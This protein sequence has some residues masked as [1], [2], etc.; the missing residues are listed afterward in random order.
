MGAIGPLVSRRRIFHR[1]LAATYRC[2]PPFPGKFRAWARAFFAAMARHPLPPELH[3]YILLAF[4]CFS[5]FVAVDAA[6]GPYIPPREVR[7]GRIGCA[8]SWRFQ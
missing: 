3:I 6:A 7:G 1:A 4:A 5:D 2:R 8:F